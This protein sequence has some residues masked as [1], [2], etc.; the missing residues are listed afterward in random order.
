M[1]WFDSD[2]QAFSIL[3]ENA[4]HFPMVITLKRYNFLRRSKVVSNRLYIISVTRREERDRIYT[5]ERQNLRRNTLAL[6]KQQLKDT[7][8]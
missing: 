3:T 6:R 5:G 7:T 1:R 8:T 4:L 2:T